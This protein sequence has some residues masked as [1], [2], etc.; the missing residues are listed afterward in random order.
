ML[1]P[2]PDGLSPEGMKAI[3]IF[4]FALIMW[5][6]NVIPIYLTSFIVIMLLTFTGAFPEKEAL[7]TLGYPVIWLM[8]SAF[9]LTSSMMKSNLA[10]RVALWIIG[11]YV[12]TQ[13]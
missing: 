12:R 1:L 9:V 13:N 11:S 7:G 3:A 8:V 10:N 5:V 6:A 4:L 2:T